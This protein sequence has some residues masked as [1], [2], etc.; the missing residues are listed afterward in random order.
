VGSLNQT[1]D[2]IDEV[3]KFLLCVMKSCGFSSRADYRPGGH[4]AVPFSSARTVSLHC[5]DFR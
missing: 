2:R 3:M 4:F 1:A 5:A